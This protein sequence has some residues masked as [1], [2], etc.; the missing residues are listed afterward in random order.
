MQSNINLLCWQHIRL[1]GVVWWFLLRID[2]V[3]CSFVLIH[4]FSKINSV[5]LPRSII[6]P[7]INHD[8]LK[9]TLSFSS[10]VCVCCL[11]VFV[12]LPPSKIYQVVNNY[13]V[14]V[15]SK[16]NYQIIILRSGRYKIIKIY[17]HH[18][19]LIWHLSAIFNVRINIFCLK[20]LF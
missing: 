5:A 16:V 9:N 10:C 6:P 17:R 4:I 15:L 18:I 12:V 20:T 11:A 2:N 14:V 13:L 3:A 1:E 8:T 19:F 7:I